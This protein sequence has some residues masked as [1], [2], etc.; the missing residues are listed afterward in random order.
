MLKLK[1]GSVRLKILF[2]DISREVVSCFLL[3]FFT[4]LHFKT[5]GC[6]SEEH[7]AAVILVALAAHH[8]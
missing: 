1:G 8:E 7:N 2:P 6:P 3:L 5:E 4:V